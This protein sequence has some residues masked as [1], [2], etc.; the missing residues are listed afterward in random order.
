M[1]MN[2]IIVSTL[3]SIILL[4]LSG[5]APGMALIKGQERID[6][7]QKSIALVSVKI[8]N[9]NKPNFQPTLQMAWVAAISEGAERGKVFMFSPPGTPYTSKDNQYNEYLLSFQLKPGTY[10][11][12]SISMVNYVPFIFRAVAVMPIYLK[13]E[14]KPNSIIYLGNIDAII[15]ERKDGEMQAGFVLPL[16]DNAVAGFSNGTFDIVINDKYDEDM[17]SFVT[18]YPVLQK[19]KV[20][21]SILPPW[22][23]LTEDECMYLCQKQY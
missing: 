4:S 10:R 8:S 20:E 2:K 13:I 1:R 15:R 23:R 7:S 22:T 6:V 11:F 18:E 14:I 17:K 19:E 9:K 5:C 21:K 16:V 12:C 3:V